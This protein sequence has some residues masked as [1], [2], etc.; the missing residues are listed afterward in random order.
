MDDSERIAGLVVD[1]AV[2]LHRRLGP[3]LLEGVYESILSRAL[4][5]R[6]LDVERQRC[7]AFEFEGMR[8]TRGL[9]V[10]L[11]INQVVVVEVKSRTHLRP[12]DMK[13]LLTY[14]RLLNL[15]VGLM[16]NFG[17]PTMKEGIR[18]VVNGY[19]LP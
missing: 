10:D 17:A 3:G 11:L 15:R 12:V 16:L 19:P 9:R 14:L 7:V 13:Q 6:G 1:S 5:G 4:A 8:F 2:R 18:R